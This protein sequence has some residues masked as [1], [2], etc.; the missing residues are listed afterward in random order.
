LLPFL[1]LFV[2]N[3]AIDGLVSY[4][5]NFREGILSYRELGALGF[6]VGIVVDTSYHAILWCLVL[7]LDFSWWGYVPVGVS[8][9]KASHL[10]RASTRMDMRFSWKQRGMVSP[11]LVINP[12]PV[13]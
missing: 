13:R 3:S 8:R 4:I 6:E 2:R 11:S 5:S 9:R 7:R 10:E 1:F 12:V